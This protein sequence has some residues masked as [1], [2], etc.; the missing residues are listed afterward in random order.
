MTDS[1]L[2]GLLVADFSRVLAGPLATMTMADLGATVIKIER[3]GTGDDTRHWGPPWLAGTDGASAY[4]DCLNRGKHSVA[5]DLD[6]PAD[7]DAAAELVRRADVLV[8]NFRPGVLARHGLD[9]PSARDL[10]PRLVY[11]S[12]TGF[13]DGAGAALPGYDFVVQAAG[14]LMSITGEPDGDPLKAGVAL[15]DALTGKDALIGVLAALRHRDRTGAG[16]HVRVNLL[17]SLLGGLT[18]QVAAYLTTGDAP[19]RM[20][21][22]HPSIA[23]YETLRCAD[24]LLAVAVG[25]DAQFARF[26]AALGV[27]GLARD[28]RFAANAARVANRPELVA[29]LE[30]ALAARTARDWEERLH[31]AGI[32]CAPVNDIASA[33]RYADDLGLAPVLDLGPGRP[34]QIRTPIDLSAA[35]PHVPSP[36]PGLDEHGDTV[37]AWLREPSDT[38]WST[39]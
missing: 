34:G 19:A 21:N 12:I 1:P 15:V 20:G 3:P 35:P 10:N 29:E 9:Y 7:R 30:R 22:R 2:S 18:N 33:V 27:D 37:R 26:A 14:G 8:E 17:S 31:T 39:P 38:P 36:P 23:P 32:A 24:G 11:A 25:T 16:Q 5:L 4:F 13:G 6:A 28:P